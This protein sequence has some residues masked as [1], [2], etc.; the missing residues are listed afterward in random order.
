MTRRFPLSANIAEEVYVF[1]YFL[2]SQNS[3][4]DAE[5]NN[6]GISQPVCTFSDRV[7]KCTKLYSGHKN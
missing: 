6:S 5:S 7:G 2:E 3:G 1:S 4:V